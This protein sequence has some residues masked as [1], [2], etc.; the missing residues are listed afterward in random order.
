MEYPRQSVLPA[1][2]I[3]ADHYPV[4]TAWSLTDEVLTEARYSL[5]GTQAEDLR[6]L[7]AQPSTVV[8]ID[9]SRNT[10][11]HFFESPGAEHTVVHFQPVANDLEHHPQGASQAIAMNALG[12]NV[13]FL[14]QNAT[15]LTKNE[16]KKVWHGDLTPLGEQRLRILEFAANEGHIELGSIALAGYSFGASDAAITSALIAE[17]GIGT[18]RSSVFGEPANITNRNVLKLL[19]DFAGPKA[20]GGKQLIDSVLLSQDPAL[21]ELWDAKRGAKTSLYMKE[22]FAHFARAILKRDN[23]WLAAALR[24]NRFTQDV[25]RGLVAQKG[26]VMVLHKD[27]DSVLTPEADFSEVERRLTIAAKLGDVSL[28]SVRSASEPWVG[29]A[30]GDNP[31]FWASLVRLSLDKTI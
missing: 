3:D 17:K 30:I 31:W 25:E 8:P 19:L 18:I 2:R 5:R 22:D 1:M 6:A 10:Y 11:Y 20:A 26:G 16:R 23:L 7:A 21:I 28:I 27:H 4:R 24:H 14:S 29:H 13:L 12:Y 9:D 15:Q